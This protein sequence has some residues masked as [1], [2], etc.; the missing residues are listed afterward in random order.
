MMQNP[1]SF[2]PKQQAA[3]H[4][5]HLPQSRHFDAVICDGA[6][7]S[8]KTTALSVGFFL[9]ACCSFH[10]QDFAVCGKTKTAL[11][12]NLLNPL[13]AMLRPMGFRI[14]DQVSKGYADISFCGRCNRLRLTADGRVKPCLHSPLEFPIK[15]LDPEGVRRQ[16][17]AACAAKPERH[18]AL[19]Y[20]QR[21]G[22][23]RS[24]NRIGG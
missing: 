9:W 7:R 21:S 22:A 24:M 18:G 5:W 1:A 4:W 12:R 3:I 14:R 2:S 19:S 20:E 13:F 11:R 15:G 16:F 6:V 23:N 17:L 8:G 10:Q